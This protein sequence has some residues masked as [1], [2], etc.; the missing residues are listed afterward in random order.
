MADRVTDASVV[1]TT[2]SQEENKTGGNAQPYMGNNTVQIAK[3]ATD[4][5]GAF[6]ASRLCGLTRRHGAC[7]IDISRLW[8][9]QHHGG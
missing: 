2:I 6:A 1:T 3:A 9:P 7:T 4:A 8:W 5:M